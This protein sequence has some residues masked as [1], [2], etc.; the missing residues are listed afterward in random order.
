MT[1]HFAQRF[2]GIQR[3]YGQHSLDVL[4]RSHVCVIGIGGVGSWAAESL[5]RSGIGRITLIDLDDVCIS[6]VNRQLHAL[7]GSVGQS[8]VMVMAERIR[9]INPSC[10]CTPVQAFL[11]E[12]NVASQLTAE[13]VFVIDAIDSV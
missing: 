7:D 12:K 5:A 4:A 10:H 9:M 2:G 3:L 6:N 1:D 11:T 13:F 8:K